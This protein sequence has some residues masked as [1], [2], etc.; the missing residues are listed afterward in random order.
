MVNHCRHGAEASIEEILD[1]RPFDY[2]TD[3]T[4]QPPGPSFMSTFELEPTTTGTVI[5]MRFAPTRKKDRAAFDQL[6][7]L[8]EQAIMGAAAAFKVEAE[9]EAEDRTGAFSE[10]A[11]PQRSA[12]G[13]L[14]DLGP[15]RIV[16]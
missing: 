11:L 10:P 2:F 7:P 1:W 4:T 14:G 6:A 9:R 8:L 5:H 15:I 13:P 16:G 3:R 12:V